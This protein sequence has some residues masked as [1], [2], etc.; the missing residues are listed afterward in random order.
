[1]KMIFL[2]MSLLFSTHFALAHETQD[3]P[4]VAPLSFAEGQIQAH[5][6]W[7]NGPNDGYES[8]LRIELRNGIDHT[9]LLFEGTLS[10]E[11]WMP[12]MN[13]GSAPTIVQPMDELRG[14]YQV[15]QIFFL[16]PG[17]WDVRVTLSRADRTS[18][19]KSFSVMV[20]PGTSG[21]HRHP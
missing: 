10:V 5:I 19:T 20:N 2:A 15:S 12:G 6:F 4:S 8:F 18:E 9:A 11:L 17:P 3:A 14:G 1:M 7:E 21:G 13:H 16:M